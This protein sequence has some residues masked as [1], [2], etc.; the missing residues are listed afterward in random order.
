MYSA[1]STSEF[2][3]I[4]WSDLSRIGPRSTHGQCATFDHSRTEWDW[5]ELIQC[6]V[7]IQ[8]DC[9]QLGIL[10]D[11]E[12]LVCMLRSI[13]SRKCLSSRQRQVWSNLNTRQLTYTNVNSILTRLEIDHLT[14]PVRS[15]WSQVHWDL[16]IESQ[17]LSLHTTTHLLVN[18]LFG[19]AESWSHVFEGKTLIWLQ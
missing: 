8:S 11:H 7:R 15:I 1:I 3:G 16:T 9:G 17:W 10:T 14:S 19:D 6:L 13:R 12:K 2:T 5:A 4:S 18:E